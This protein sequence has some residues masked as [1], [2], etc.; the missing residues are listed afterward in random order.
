MWLKHIIGNWTGAFIGGFLPFLPGDI[1]KAV[2]V[3]ILAPRL[4]RIVADK[5]RA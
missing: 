4:R 1:L 3:A 5:L 2:A